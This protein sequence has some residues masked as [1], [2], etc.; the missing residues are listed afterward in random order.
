MVQEFTYEQRILSVLMGLRHDLRKS[1]AFLEEETYNSPLSECVPHLY[2]PYKGDPKFVETL[3]GT[4]RHRVTPF[5]GQLKMSIV[6][7]G[8]SCFYPPPDVI[9]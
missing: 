2:G 3:A 7:C 4:F 5:L 8:E 1:T 6:E 9:V